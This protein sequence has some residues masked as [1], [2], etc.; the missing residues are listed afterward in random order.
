MHHFD[1]IWQQLRI[2]KLHSNLV[3]SV[4]PSTL[5]LLTGR[6]TIIVLHTQR[7]GNIRTPVSRFISVM[8]AHS[9]IV[10]MDWVTGMP[11][12]THIRS[13][14]LEWPP[15]LNFKDRNLRNG[16]T[17][18]HGYSGLLV[19]TCSSYTLLTQRYMILSDRPW[20]TARFSTTTQR[21]CVIIYNHT[22]YIAGQ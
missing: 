22:P 8:I 17:K 1:R 15:N 16:T 11:I 13:L 20:M 10:T 3:K 18:R 6:S 21:W 2:G 12:R 14:D 5:V 7:Y 4:V 19:G 9:A